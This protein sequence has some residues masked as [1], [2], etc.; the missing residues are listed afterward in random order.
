MELKLAERAAERV[1]V[2]AAHPDDIEFGVAGSVAK[3][4]AQGAQVSYVIVTDGSAGSNEPGV[5]IHEL[6]RQR[7]AEQRVAA[8]VVGVTDVRFLGYRDG[9]LEP[10]I[11]LRRELTRIIRELKP[12]RVITQDPTTVFVETGY[13]NHPDHRAAAEAAV[14]ATFPSAGT[15]PIFPELLDEG[16]EPHNVAELWLMLSME[17]TH[18][19]DIA[20]VMDTKIEALLK[21][22]SQLGPEVVDWIREMNVEMGK[23]AGVE[24]AEVYRIMTLVEEPREVITEAHE[25]MA[26]SD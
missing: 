15:R 22:E 2:I 10:T 12:D 9:T 3:W 13:I 16:L 8:E 20:D 5:D 11:A 19:V 24:Y 1:L 23:L 4:T 18:A 25:E 14:Y 26:E 21:H 17:P 6:A 7:E